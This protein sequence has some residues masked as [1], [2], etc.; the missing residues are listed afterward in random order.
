MR[1]FPRPQYSWATISSSQGKRVMIRG[2]ASEPDRT[3]AFQRHLLAPLL[4]G[5]WALRHD[6]RLVDA[7]CIELADQLDATI[8]TTDSAV[9]SATPT[10]DRIQ[11]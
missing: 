11:P 2:T 8:V 5:A 10:A 1:L 7:L 4:S 9:A 3:G 6:V